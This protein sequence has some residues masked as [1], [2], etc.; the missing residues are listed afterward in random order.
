[1]IMEVSAE[2][3]RHWLE[4]D[5]AILVDV[6]EPEEFAR[7]HIPYARSI[8]LGALPSALYDLQRSHG[9]KLVF[10]CQSGMRSAAAC[11]LT[12]APP[13]APAYTLS[14][15]IA[16]WQEAGLPVIASHTAGKTL[17]IMRQVQIVV[18]SL[19]VLSVLAGIF[20]SPHAFLLPAFFGAGLLMAG[21]TGWCGMARLLML[22]PWNRAPLTDGHSNGKQNG[23]GCRI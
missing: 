9:R 13:H 11:T 18:G 19:I 2:N 15:G 12:N 22:M 14:G 8:P 3:L 10:H 5:E 23:A 1:M 16:A 4:R 7:A 6:R 21:L 17:P 20:I